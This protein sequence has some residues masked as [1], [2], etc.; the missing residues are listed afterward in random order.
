MKILASLILIIISIP[1]FLF[2]IYE[3]KKGS[4]SFGLFITICN[5]FNI[6]I[7]AISI[8]SELQD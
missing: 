6:T 7:N 1:L 2:G 5:T 4:I 3:I 8:I